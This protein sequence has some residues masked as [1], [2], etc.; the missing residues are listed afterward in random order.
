MPRKKTLFKDKP[1]AVE[2]DYI[3][4]K[5][6]GKRISQIS[7]RKHR[8]IKDIKRLER[9]S[10]R[11][12]D[13]LFVIEGF[14]S[15]SEAVSFGFELKAVLFVSEKREEVLS[16]LD[17]SSNF[18]E[19]FEVTQ[20][21]MDWIS[22]VVN[23]QG[24]LAV[25]NYIDVPLDKALERSSSM[26]VV[27]DGV[28]DPGNLGAIIRVADASGADSFIAGEGSCDI[29]NRKVVRSSAGSL[30]HFPVSRNV[31][32]SIALGDIKS[33]GFT[34]FGLDP[35]GVKN[36]L[37]ADMTM[38]FAVIVGNEAHGISSRCKQ[39]VDELLFIE[40]P[41]KAESLNVACSASI[42]L[43]EALRQRRG[44]LERNNERN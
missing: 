42:V 44:I 26:V 31:D 7:S 28:N 21:L 12:R 38:P 8:L 20:D 2:T 33:R 13:R 23:S 18:P 10:Y 17:F 3:E 29:Y 15:L 32:L 40:M 37:D 14:N 19:L 16:I 9:R 35:N 1:E 30:F 24:V 41:G 5:R 22:D 27:A 34:V 39:E 43:F 36:Y 11:D 25:L 6:S 4:A